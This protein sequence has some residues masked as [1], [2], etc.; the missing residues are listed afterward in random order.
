MHTD[1]GK[2]GESVN[3]QFDAMNG[4]LSDPA[5]AGLCAKQHATS[6]LLTRL[7]HGG[8]VRATA[9][10]CGTKLGQPARDTQTDVAGSK[11]KMIAAVSPAT[12]SVGLSAAKR[13]E[14]KQ[15]LRNE[16]AHSGKRTVQ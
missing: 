7:E 2:Q 9:S 4:W 13:A 14:T 15:A 3:T 6:A 8:C 11:R 5:H 16:G 10:E 12:G 1:N